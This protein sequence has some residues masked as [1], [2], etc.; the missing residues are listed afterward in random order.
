ML[1]YI[2]S[3]LCACVLH[4][5][6]FP[7][8]SKY[9]P[10]Q[11]RLGTDLSYIVASFLSKER[12]QYE[13]NADIDINRFLVTGD[14]GTGSW[15]INEQDY[16]YKNSGS[17]I[18]FGLDYNFVKPSPDNN[19]IYI[20]LRYALAQFTED[21][22]F[23]IED[24]LY[25]SYTREVADIDRTG[26]WIEFVTGMKVRVW[27]GLYLGWTAKLKFAS[28]VSSPPATFAPFWMPGFGKTAE[29]SYWGLNYQIYYRIP[30]FRKKSV[31]TE[32]LLG[33]GE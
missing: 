17:Y 22:T 15:E 8:G 3:L 6:A 14:Y 20:G 23:R 33:P 32:E 5:Q 4:L 13:F 7:Q 18:R 9:I 1:R 24:P 25:G 21:F 27:Q 2:I 11:L 16:D 10:S 12:S 29:D 30:L 26:S 31:P 28:S 19:A